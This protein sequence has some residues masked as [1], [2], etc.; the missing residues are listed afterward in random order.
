MWAPGERDPRRTARMR[1]AQRTHAV[2]P[3]LARHLDD[4]VDHVGRRADCW[5]PVG[6]DTV[7]FGWVTAAPVIL[8]RSSS[9]SASKTMISSMRL[10]IRG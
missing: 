4:P 1:A 7:P 10:M 3:V 2:R 9:F 5:L 8:R 6:E